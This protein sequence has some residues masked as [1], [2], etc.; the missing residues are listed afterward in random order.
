MNRVRELVGASRAYKQGM[1]GEGIGAA[2]LA[3]G[4]NGE[5][6]DLQGRLVSSYNYLTG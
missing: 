6:P 1:F 4:I 5:H 3:S 2:V